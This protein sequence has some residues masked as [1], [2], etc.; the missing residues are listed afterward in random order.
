MAGSVAFSHELSRVH[1]PQRS[2]DRPTQGGRYHALMLNPLLS[3]LDAGEVVILDGGLATELEHR[4]SDLGDELWSARLLID[5]PDLIRA[6][7]ADYLRA[8]ADVVIGASYQ[9]STRGF[10]A[11]GL[12]D[13]ATD[14][15]LTQATAIA[16][17][18]RDSFW[19]DSACPAGRR[20][21]LV[22][23]S[24]GPYGAVLADGSEY[25]G[26]YGGGVDSSGDH[27]ISIEA[28][29]EFHSPRL[30]T[31]SASGPDLLALETIPSLDEADALIR[32]LEAAQGPPAWLSVTCR[33]ERSVAHGEPIEAVAERAH[34]CDRIVAFGVNCTAPGLIEPLLR[35]AAGVT[36]M[37]LVAYPNRG[38]VWDAAARSWVGGSGAG[39]SALSELAARW[40]EAGAHLIGGCCRTTPADIRALAAMLR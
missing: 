18:A 37:P 34:D 40:R 19:R 10:A 9:A 20:R 5:D 29:A 38:E 24:V 36:D 17:S 23:A 2:V 1:D 4:G 35:R 14:A 25:S 31:L 33:D 28:L 15:L 12:D 22:A 6:V 32:C 39:S 11:R 8:G 13:A 30:A 3:W 7:H 27:T 16:R 26:N 21:P